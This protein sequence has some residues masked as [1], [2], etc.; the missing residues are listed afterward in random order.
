MRERN[1]SF[2]RVTITE[3]VFKKA[4][5]RAKTQVVFENSHR[6]EEANEVG[7]LGEMIAERWMQK[8]NIEYEPELDKTTH[9]YIVGKNITIDVKTKDRTVVPKSN[10]DNSAPLYNHE[11]QRPDYFLFISLQRD[12][13]SKSKDLRRFRT[14][15]IVGSISYKELDKIGIP[16][17]ENEKDWRNGTK[18]WTDCLNIEMWQLVSINETIKLF[19]G[20]IDNPMLEAMPNIK[21]IQE[22]KARIKN[23]QIKE[24]KLPDISK[25]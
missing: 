9:D 23:G 13:N 12:K 3:E 8:E 22:M 19:K 1:I 6:Q 11:H 20:E 24:R 5:L 4:E 7:C 2:T 10:Y 18:F 16:F 17:L 14:A 21:I 25:F 15:Y